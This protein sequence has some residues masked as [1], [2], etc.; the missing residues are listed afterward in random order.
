MTNSKKKQS[1][2]LNRFTRKEI[3]PYLSENEKEKIKLH[4]S[5]INEL[6]SIL[7]QLISKTDPQIITILAL[8]PSDLNSIEFNWKNAL[9][10]FEEKNEENTDNKEREKLFKE[11]QKRLKPLFPWRK[12]FRNT[13]MKS[14]TWLKTG[15]VL[16]RKPRKCWWIG[17]LV[18]RM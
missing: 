5:K 12:K 17:K 11:M 16:C 10:A 8:Q 15:P 2:Y 9:K 3:W 4:L 1:P 14:R 6:N 7:L 18:N 13:V